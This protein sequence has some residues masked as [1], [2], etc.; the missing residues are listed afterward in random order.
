[1]NFKD[2]KLVRDIIWYEGT[3]LAEYEMR[4]KTYL[5]KWVDIDDDHT[6]HTWLVLE[7]ESEILGLYYAKLLTLRQV[8]ERAVNA[9]VQDGFINPGDFVGDAAWIDIEDVPEDWKARSNSY[10][11]ER[12]CYA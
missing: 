8:E 12:L 10:Y 1:M 7:V 4:D 2:A 3:L 11:D 6:F 9:F 5:V